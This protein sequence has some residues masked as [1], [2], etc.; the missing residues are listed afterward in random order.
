MAHATKTDSIDNFTSEG[1]DIA[2][3]S[4]EFPVLLFS[5]SNGPRLCP[6][7]GRHSRATKS[8]SRA[9]LSFISPCTACL[10]F[11]QQTGVTSAAKICTQHRDKVST[12]P[13]AN[14]N[15]YGLIPRLFAGGEVGPYPA[16]P[17]E[18]LPIRIRY[19][20]G[21]AWD[22]VFLDG[23]VGFDDTAQLSAT[24]RSYCA[25]SMSPST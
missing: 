23:D 9:S 14:D 25:S 3:P 7:L 13:P 17:E 24:T 5:H 15:I 22:R 19:E 18:V 21:G 11:L 2:S 4:R 16:G 12:Q 6:A 8:V 20:G 1:I 10:R